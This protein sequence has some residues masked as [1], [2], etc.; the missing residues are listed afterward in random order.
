M[1]AMRSPAP[2]RRALRVLVLSVC[3]ASL[4]Q[5]QSSRAV[6]VSGA[7]IRLTKMSG[8]RHGG[9]LVTL[10]RDSL[11]MAAGD[12]NVTSH[13]LSSIARLEIEEHRHRNVQRG[14]VIGTL[15]GAATGAIVGAVEFGHP[16]LVFD[17]PGEM[18]AWGMAFGAGGGL[19]VGGAVGAIPHSRWRTVPLDGSHVGVQ[20]RPL[21]AGGHG[22]LLAFTL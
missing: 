21:P 15:I 9:R 16:D 20:V 2:L 3:F 4:G 22:I 19:I 18:A 7:R 10:G 11:S 14:M 13:A 17:T 12:G 5:A 6:I 1:S 8:E